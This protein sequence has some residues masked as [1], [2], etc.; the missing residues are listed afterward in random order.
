MYKAPNSLS[1]MR[2]HI[3]EPILESIVNPL[4]NLY[5]SNFIILQDGKLLDESLPP[6]DLNLN[7]NICLMA[8]GSLTASP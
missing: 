2:I 5:N 7:N 8:L 3:A 6:K 1:K 4:H